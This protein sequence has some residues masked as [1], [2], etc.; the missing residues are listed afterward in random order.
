[1]VGS[2]FRVIA[3]ATRVGLRMEMAEIHKQGRPVGR[4]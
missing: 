1:M 3:V 4:C 2:V